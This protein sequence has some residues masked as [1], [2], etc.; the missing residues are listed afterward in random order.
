MLCK[1][2]VSIY[3]G[4]CAEVSVTEGTEMVSF[5]VQSHVDTEVPVLNFA[6]TRQGGIAAAVFVMFLF[7]S[8]CTV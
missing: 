4:R 8:Q 6:V 5:S 3:L 1:N 7:R 2:L